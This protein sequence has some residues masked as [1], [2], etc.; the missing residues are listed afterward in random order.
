MRI[1]FQCLSKIMKINVNE[2]SRMLTVLVIPLWLV[3]MTVLFFLEGSEILISREVAKTVD[4]MKTKP[5]QYRYLYFPF[6]ERTSSY[7]NIGTLGL[8]HLTYI[9]LIVI[10]VGRIC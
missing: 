9:P 8:I 3:R 10:S 7:R 5:H 1:F 6:V 4:L 2:M